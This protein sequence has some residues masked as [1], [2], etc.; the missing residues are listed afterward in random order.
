MTS[1]SGITAPVS[2]DNFEIPLIDFA[3]FREVDEKAKTETARSI[4]S[5]FQRASFI[6]LRNHGISKA[7]VDRAFEDSAKFFKRPI[8][9]KEELAWTSPESNRGY[10]RQG[11]ENLAKDAVDKS[12]NAEKE[13]VVELKDL[14]ET[15]NFGREG[16]VFE[17]HWPDSFDDEGKVFK[18]NMV[19][20][21]NECQLLN[22]Q[23]MRAIAVGLGIQEDWFDSFCDAANNNLRLLHYPEVRAEVFQKNKLQVRA[24]AHT[25]Y[26]SINLLFQDMTG[27]LQ[28]QTPDGSFIDATPIPD[29]VVINAGD[30]LARWS[31]DTIKS[32][33]HR[34][35][36]P[37]RDSQAEQTYP[38]RYSIAYFCIPNTDSLIEAIPGTYDDACDKKYPGIRSGE[39]LVQRL[40]ATI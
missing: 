18:G 15:M 19:T 30:M 4:L 40:A 35:V 28:V 12:V 26:G 8:A 34:V 23:I 3:A 5:G 16:D 14:K 2:A 33:K 36:E 32:T 10:V 1:D 11:K 22:I 31:N 21:F 13:Q 9:Q 7:T 24:G 6:Y 20:F 25:D 39:Y 27:G 17:N 29:T 37:A 38:A